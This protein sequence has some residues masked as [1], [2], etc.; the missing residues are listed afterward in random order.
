MTEFGSFLPLLAKLHTQPYLHISVFPECRL[1]RGVG[2]LVAIARFE[3]TIKGPK[4]FVLPLHYTA[5]YSVA[6]HTT[7][8]RTYIRWKLMFSDAVWVS[9][10]VVAHR[11]IP[12]IYRLHTNGAIGN[13]LVS[14][15]GIEPTRP[16]G[17]H[18]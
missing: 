3:L 12:T 9:P 16:A 8:I 10:K 4:P 13:R 7:D 17:S 14:M 2:S 15:V 11:Y 18:H 5:I 6:F 1:P